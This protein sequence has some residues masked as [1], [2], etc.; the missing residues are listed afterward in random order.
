MDELLVE[1]YLPAAGKTYD[2]E[3]P[4]TAKLSTVTNL[5]ANALEELSEGQYINDGKAILTNRDTGDIFNINL[6]AYELGLING[7][8]LILI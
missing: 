6:S 1:V 5:I 3:I 7:S 8:R 4:Y 2:V